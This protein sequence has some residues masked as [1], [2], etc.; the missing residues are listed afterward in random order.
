MKKFIA[1]LMVTLIILVSLVGCSTG[2]N[3]N[4]PENSNQKVADSSESKTD[5]PSKK[6]TLI[7]PWSA[8]GITDRVARVFAPLFEK[9]LGQPITVVN[10]EGASGAI[11]TEFA[12]GEPN[13][14]YTVLFSAETPA[15]FQVMGTSKLGF[16]DF[17][18]LKML[19][20]DLK[21]VVVPKNSPYNTFEELVADIK[22]NPGKI[23]MSYSGPGASGH[24]QGLL[25]KQLGLDV[26]MTPYGGGNPSMIATIS[27]EVDFTF[28]NY[29]TVKD[30]LKVGD[31]RALA[32]FDNKKSDALPDVPPMTDVLPEADPYLP[33]YF[34]NSLLVK[35]GTSDE[36]KNVLIE[37]AEKALQEPEWKE[38]VESQSYTTL[39]HLTVEEIDD[40]WAK[41]TSITSWLLYDAGVA[42]N[43]PEDFGIK[44]FEE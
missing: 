14:G 26:S 16:S 5:F 32:L 11:G 25:F 35:K 39:D 36:V 31:L 23:K 9:N 18:A 27:G 38:F 43:N 20:Q 42:Q 17:D 19:I 3:S 2:G 24:I 6:I 28:G 12:H 34:P 4:T 30:Y 22:A 7:V 1:L 21:V 33:L 8:G 13:D 41:F 44:R 37:A 29:G 10:K 40:Y 15:V